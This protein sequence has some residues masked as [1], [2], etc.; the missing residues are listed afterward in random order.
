MSLSQRIQYSCTCTLQIC[1]LC[2]NMSHVRT[3]IPLPQSYYIRLMYVHHVL[4]LLHHSIVCI[5]NVEIYILYLQVRG[6]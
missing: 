1:T 6:G 3:Y 2:L 4:V 5:A